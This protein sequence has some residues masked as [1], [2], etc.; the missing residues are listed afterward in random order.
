MG[1]PDESAQPKGHG[2]AHQHLNNLRQDLN[3]LYLS[4]PSWKLL[5]SLA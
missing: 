2:S 3:L 1:Q 4:F 5:W